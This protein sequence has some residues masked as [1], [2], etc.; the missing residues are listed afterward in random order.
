[1]EGQEQIYP[2]SRVITD[3]DGNPFVA[4]EYL[5]RIPAFAPNLTIRDIFS[6]DSVKVETPGAETIRFK[7]HVFVSVNYMNILQASAGTQPLHLRVTAHE[8]YDGYQ[9]VGV[10]LEDIDGNEIP[11]ARPARAAREDA[12]P[13]VVHRV[14]SEDGQQSDEEAPAFFGDDNYMERHDTPYE[15]VPVAAAP[16]RRTIKAC[17]QC[18]VRKT[19]CSGTL[20]CEA[21]DKRNGN[22]TYLDASSRIQPA[23]VEKEQVAEQSSNQDEDGQNSPRDGTPSV[24]QGQDQ[25]QDE[26]EII[27]VTGDIPLRQ[28]PH[29]RDWAGNSSTDPTDDRSHQPQQ[30]PQAARCRQDQ[31]VLE[32]TPCRPQ[33]FPPSQQSS[34]PQG[35]AL[36]KQLRDLKLTDKATVT[37]L[38]DNELPPALDKVKYA[39]DELVHLATLANGDSFSMRIFRDLHARRE[40]LSFPTLKDA[41]LLDVPMT[42]YQKFE[43]QTILSNVVHTESGKDLSIQLSSIQ[44]R[45]WYANHAHGA[46]RSLK[47]V[48]HEVDD[49][50]KDANFHLEEGE[51]LAT[52]KRVVDDFHVAMNKACAIGPRDIE[53]PM[54]NG[55]LREVYIPGAR[56]VGPQFVLPLGRLYITRHSNAGPEPLHRFVLIDTTTPR[57]AVWLMGRRRNSSGETLN[58][59]VLADYFHSWKLGSTDDNRD[60]GLM[61]DGEG[62]DEVRL[63]KSKLLMQG[64]TDPGHDVVLFKRVDQ[65]R[66]KEAIRAGWGVDANSQNASPN[67][68]DQQR[69]PRR[70]QQGSPLQ[71]ALR[72]SA[73]RAQACQTPTR[74]RPRPDHEEEENAGPSRRMRPDRETAWSAIS[75][76]YP[77]ILQR[78]KS[79][80]T[81]P[82]L[83]RLLDLPAVRSLVQHKVSGRGSVFSLGTGGASIANQNALAALSQASGLTAA[84]PCERCQEGK[85]MW[86]G[87]VQSPAQLGDQPTYHGNPCANCVYQGRG[88]TCSFRP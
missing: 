80:P 21:C 18:R 46:F 22:C 51:G 11:V 72:N 84:I 1:M 4:E 69:T 25:D 2:H 54:F 9:K 41:A 5:D 59:V 60:G 15:D 64:L 3:D 45:L 33:P 66:V 82:A 56:H 88:S 28:G 26:P 71:I 12:P 40:D 10:R 27:D 8:T 35:R 53:H 87:C 38:L 48:V 42:A 6:L 7:D 57:M 30:H 39:Q 43:L 13:V 36:V 74:K 81:A 49:L 58:L 77:I 20:P 68:R 73:A 37:A 79:R 65:T 24:N 62:E 50:L 52:C 61:M 34:S 67:T 75:N 83:S 23:V 85:G 17:E 31:D 63:R 32:V 55:I 44:Q 16:A 78:Y 29:L 19:K 86:V 47:E 76:A 14:E 70:D